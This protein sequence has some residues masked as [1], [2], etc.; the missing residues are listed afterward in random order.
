MLPEFVCE[1]DAVEA[2]L[3]LAATAA[4]PPPESDP[5]AP[6]AVAPP[7]SA[8]WVTALAPTAVVV[9]V[10]LVVGFTAAIRPLTTRL[11]IGVP[12]PVTAS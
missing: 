1:L 6:I 9:L 7:L 12:R 4:A 8:A 10:V 11:A 3:T 5:V 2:A